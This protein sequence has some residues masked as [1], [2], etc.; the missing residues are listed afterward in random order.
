MNRE[1]RRQ[2]FWLSARQGFVMGLWHQAMFTL[3]ILM[4]FT[5]A[6]RVGLGWMF[7]GSAM[8]V[9]ATGVLLAYKMKLYPFTEKRNHW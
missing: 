7:V 4:P 5:W 6:A 2:E 9:L 3:A 8:V 1:E